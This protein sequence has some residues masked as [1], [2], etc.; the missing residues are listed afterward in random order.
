[1]YVILTL[2]AFIL[3]SIFVPVGILV[4]TI[5]SCVRGQM[6]EYYKGVAIAC[7]QFGNTACCEMFNLLL[8]K[9]GGYKFGNPDETVS[10]VLSKNYE[11]KT[12]KIAGKVLTKILNF[13]SPNHI[14]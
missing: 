6:Q 1:M 11:L 4:G 3:L 13:I 5:V 2:I 8:I 9:K 12:L 10:E 7:D 14:H